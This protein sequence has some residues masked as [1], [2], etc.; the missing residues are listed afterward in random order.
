MRH[1]RGVGIAFILLFALA[2]VLIP[3]QHVAAGGLNSRCAIAADQIIPGN[4]Y[5]VCDTLEIDGTVQGDVVAAAAQ[6]TVNGAITG[7][8]L[9]LTGDTIVKGAIGHNVRLM[10]GRLLVAPGARLADAD[11]AWLGLSAEIH[12]PVPGNL[13]VSGYQALVDAPVGRDVRFEGAALTVQNSI[14]GRLD[15]AIHDSFRPPDIPAFDLQFAP[16][17]FVL[18]G[19]IAGDNALLVPGDAPFLSRLGDFLVMLLK[20]TLA[21][22][23]VGIVIMLPASR[24]LSTATQSIRSKPLASLG[25]GALTF[26]LF[27]PAAGVLVVIS[28]LILGIGTALT[29]TEIT[30]FLALLLL[31]LDLAIIGA[32]TVIIGFGARVVIVYLVGQWIARHVFQTAGTVAFQV[33]TIV[34]GAFL[35]SLVSDLPFIGLPLNVIGVCFGLGAIGLEIR[36]WVRD[37]QVR[38][39][40]SPEESP[41]LASGGAPA[42][43]LEPPE[44]PESLPG[45][46]NLPEGFTWFDS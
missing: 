32:M 6:I 30:P 42:P 44:T 10:G 21:L 19:H 8:L 11:L 37:R 41:N 28:L 7:D 3:A 15:G 24:P 36:T 17:G 20:D 38:R 35:Y 46:D 40:L 2:I 1:F 16:S 12:A 14:G 13:Y 27:L 22:S 31:G 5:A 23:L 26:V 9:A 4:L 45:M 33:G 34:V 25:V 18:N 29:L 43:L 39:E